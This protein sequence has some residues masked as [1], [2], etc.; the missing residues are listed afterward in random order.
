VRRAEDALH[1][2]RRRCILAGRDDSG[3]LPA[4]DLDGETGPGH[5]DDRPPWNFVGDDVAHQLQRVGLDAFRGDRQHRLFAHAA[6]AGAH[7]VGYD[8]RVALFFGLAVSLTALP[9]SVRILSEMGWVNTDVGQTIITAGLLC[10][11]AG[12]SV[13]GVITNWDA[14]TSGDLSVTAIVVAKILAFFGAVFV[15]ER[16]LSARE[17]WLSKRL[18]A[19]S[20]RLLSRG[21]AFSAPLLL[22]FGFSVLAESLG[23][24]FV[25]GTF[26]G[27]VI[28]AEHVFPPHEG[29]RLR[30][31]IGAIADGFLAP[32][33]FAY[34]GLVAVTLD[35]ALSWLW[36]VL[37]S[38]AAF[39]KIAGS[40]VGAR[41]GGFQSWSA[42][43]IAVGMNGRGAMELVIALV[44]LELG[45]IPGNLFS[46]FV[47]LGLVTTLMTP[48][49]LRKLASLARDRGESTTTPSEPRGAS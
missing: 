19:G 32:I 1:R 7:H 31:S 15:A 47:L 18:V 34:L 13:L 16:V 22:V 30:A 21:A 3:R 48:F 33:F 25:I 29:E 4:G 11:I 44:A 43:L 37:L 17:A 49:A 26:F 39:G 36:A 20:H 27:A 42:S 35:P 46:I 28:V 45:I 38:V 40:Y 14:L 24:H 5:G 41:F 23:L 10:D 2:G 9:V 6:R 8:A 12:L